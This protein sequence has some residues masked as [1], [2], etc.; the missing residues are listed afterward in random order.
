MSK[1][2]FEQNLKECGL[3]SSESAIYLYILEFGTSSP[4]NI[5]KGT[6]I[7]R[8][9]C[10]SLLNSLQ[11]KG[12]IEYHIKGKRKVYSPRDP[13][14]LVQ[15]QESRL[16]SIQRLLPDLQ[17]LYST[18]KNK[19]RIEFFEGFEQMKEIWHRSCSAKHVRGMTSTKLL[20][21]HSAK[22]FKEYQRKL[23]RKGVLL[24]DILTSDSIGGPMQSC[25]EIMGPMYEV[26][27]L[28]KEQ[29]SALPTDILI[30]NDSFALMNIT[31]PVASTVITDPHMA[32]TMRI[33]Y[34]LAWQQLN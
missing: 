31:D 14:A 6:G 17:D 25:K 29:H 33:M 1:Q 12:L 21:K 13:L 4:P 8:T 30:W 20:F 5:A 15:F 22:F 27:I 3:T 28:P 26:R 23:M 11:K 24:Q 7:A 16:A 19:P 2:L 34:D 9:N 18:Q 10:Y 32:E